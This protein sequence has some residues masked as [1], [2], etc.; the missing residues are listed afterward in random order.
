MWHVARPGGAYRGSVEG[1]HPVGAPST[2]GVPDFG[3]GGQQV[4]FGQSHHGLVGGRRVT[5]D[6]PEAE[7]EETTMSGHALVEK[8]LDCVK[9]GDAE[10]LA[11]LYA[12]DG[13]VHDPLSPEPVRG[14][15][16]IAAVFS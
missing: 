9:R 2:I 10:G 8:Y 11:A 15:E 1:G 3:D 4:E 13:V 6:T 7:R 16:A 5:G 12:V 14:R